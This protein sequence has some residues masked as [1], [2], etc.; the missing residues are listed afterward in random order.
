MKNIKHILVVRGAYGEMYEP[1]WVRALRENGYSVALF[2]SHE[3][4]GQDLISRVERRINWG[5]RIARMKRRLLNTVNTQ[6]PD[7]TL[8]YQGHYFDKDFIEILK[9]KTFVAGYHN[10]DPFGPQRTML[11]YRLL[12]NAIPSYDCYHFYRRSNVLE[13]NSAG[14]RNADLLMPYYIPWID[15][16]RSD[17]QSF[18][19]DLVYIGHYEND[20]RAI[21]LNSAHRAGHKV[22]VRG[23]SKYWAS[24]LDQSLVNANEPLSPVFGDA[25]RVALSEAKIAAC[26]FSKWN[27]DG[28]T[29]RAFEIPACGVFM[30]SERTEEM[31]SL[32]EEDIHAVYFESVDEFVDKV[33]FY[34]KNEN[35]RERI[36]SQGRQHVISSGHDIYSRMQQWTADVIRWK[37]D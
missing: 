3:S 1:A 14:L 30:L 12:I 10:D 32:F 22:I 37:N 23:E 5:P 13:A 9:E 24:F 27:R 29:R 26:F 6:H 19:T 16:P 31:L 25:Y 28:Y 34:V 21:C 15:Y 17:R 4:I 2:D 18:S 8:L 7:I 33:R 35:A 36:A 11:R 20:D